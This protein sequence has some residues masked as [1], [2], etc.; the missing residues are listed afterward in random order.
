MFA[1]YSPLFTSGLLSESNS[2]S[3]SR[4][5]SLDHSRP[6]QP[7]G[8]LPVD[9]NR[10]SFYEPFASED[11]GILF[12]LAP[13][14]RRS[15]LGNSFLSLDLAESRTMR[16]MSL[17]R[18]DTMTSRATTLGG[19]APASPE[20]G[21]SCPLPPTVG[22][23][24]FSTLGRRPSP[25]P[26]VRH[27]S[28]EALPKVK[29]LPAFQLPE[30]PK[31][32][33]DLAVTIPSAFSADLPSLHRSSHS[34][35]SV[36]SPISPLIS[37]IERSYFSFSPPTSPPAERTSFDWPQPPRSAPPSMPLRSRP[38]VRST[39]SF[40]TRQVNRSA[41]L[42]ALEGRV[43]RKTRTRT[44]P[45][46][47]M[48]MSDDED[49]MDLEVCEALG[50]PSKPAPAPHVRATTLLEILQEDEDVVMPSTPSHKRLASTPSSGKSRSRRGTIENLL[51]PLTNFIDFRDED[52]ATRG[53]RSFVE[54][55]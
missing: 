5:P 29:P 53:W 30:L 7:R 41:A 4:R 22:Y 9:V 28:R 34:E 38:S 47:F 8:S 54:I 20:A 40:K 50:F 6:N 44:R 24:S 39:V 15:E 55:S 23:A 36:L 51:L 14:R 10:D 27:S 13:R 12:T 16:S 46:N 1:Q 42:A 32:R 11:D 31:T 45:S 21:P 43:A 48:S 2:P 49:D 37:P 35:S 18:K 33:A 25:K 26:L 19:S 52:G 17:R 3:S